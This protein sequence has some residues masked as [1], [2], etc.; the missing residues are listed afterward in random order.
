[1][2]QMDVQVILNA[3]DPETDVLEF[4]IQEG[5]IITVNLN[6][7]SCQND[8]KNVFAAL[9][10]L[11]VS[12]DIKLQLTFADGYTRGLYKDVCTEYIQDIQRE[13]DEVKMIIRRESNIEN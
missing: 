12:N 2:N 6:Q 4:R 7:A 1:M 10:D 9:L 5:Q 3:I 11:S 13:I 8:F